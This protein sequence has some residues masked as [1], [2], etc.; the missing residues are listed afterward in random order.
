MANM[1]RLMRDAVTFVAADATMPRVLYYARAHSSWPYPASV[2]LLDGMGVV[3]SNFAR[4][5]K[6]SQ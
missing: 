5:S 6:A 2:V 4:P 3:V 1:A